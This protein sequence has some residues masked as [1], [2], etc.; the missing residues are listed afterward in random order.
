MTTLKAYTEIGFGN[1]T[2]ISTEIEYPDG[3]ETRQ[4]G[5]LRCMKVN[6]VYARLWLG[7]KVFILSSREGFVSQ[8]KNRSAFKALIGISGDVTERPS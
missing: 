4:R 6:G 5:F 8:R 2:F 7:K 3:S 1:E